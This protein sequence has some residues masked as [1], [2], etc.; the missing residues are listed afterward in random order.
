MAPCKRS[1][2]FFSDVANDLCADVARGFS[3]DRGSGLTGILA[4][5][6]FAKMLREHSMDEGQGRA[7]FCGSTRMS[8]HHTTSIG[9]SIQGRLRQTISPDGFPHAV[10]GREWRAPSHGTDAVRRASLVNCHF[11]R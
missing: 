5:M 2:L 7:P 3:H 4:H 10:K 11:L 8:R 1:A 9:L 6:D